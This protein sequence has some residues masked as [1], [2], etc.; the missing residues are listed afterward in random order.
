MKSYSETGNAKNVA[1]LEDLI[2]FVLALGIIYNP[3]RNALKVVSLNALLT[4]ARSALLSVKNAANAFFSATNEREI[5]FANIRSF[6][7]RILNALDSTEAS[8]QLVND[9]RTINRKIQGKR[10]KKI[11]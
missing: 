2:A 5:A 10:A 6:T 1:N 8:E 4:A 9:A 11:D 3:V 7:T